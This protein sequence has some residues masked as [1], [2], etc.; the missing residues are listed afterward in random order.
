MKMFN[1]GNFIMMNYFVGNL[2]FVLNRKHLIVILLSLEL[3]VLN[4]FLVMY[5]YLYI[6]M[7]NSIYILVMFMILSV[8]E[9]VLGIS[10]LV[11]LIRSYGN[12][13]LS[14]YNLL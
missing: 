4:L 5:L 13:Y 11:Y 7:M 12:D 3:I 9:G 10:I 14:T 6:N 8:S 2:M 1:L